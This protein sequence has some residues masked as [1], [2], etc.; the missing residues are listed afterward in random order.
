MKRRFFAFIHGM[1]PTPLNEHNI[2]L[3]TLNINVQINAYNIYW[4]LYFTRFH[5]HHCHWQCHS[6][7]WATPESLSVENKLHYTFEFAPDSKQPYTDSVGGGEMWGASS[8]APFSIHCYCSCHVCSHPY[9]CLHILCILIHNMLTFAKRFRYLLLY[10]EC[11]THN[12][13]SHTFDVNV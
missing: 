5:S 11:S 6:G 8:L 4:I 1:P 9:L 7:S 13:T 3:H 10:F 12:T 2:F